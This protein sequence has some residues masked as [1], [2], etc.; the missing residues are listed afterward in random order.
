[1]P[2]KI[3]RFRPT[4]A[5]VTATLALFVALG[6]TSYAALS[7]PANSVGSAQVKNGS[8]LKKDFKAGQLPA[9]KRGPAGARGAAGAAGAA[10][11]TGATG[12]SGAAGTARAYAQI[13]AAGALDT[14]VNSKGITVSHPTSG[15]YCIAFD[16]ALGIG[17]NAFIMANP[18]P[19]VNA[20]YPIELRWASTP[21]CPAGQLG[22]I[23]YIDTA[24]TA[25]DRSFQILVP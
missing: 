25:G 7:L 18:L 23:T 4:Y 8:L 16:A 1:M 17:V 21:T 15:W 14:S 13:T 12:P 20:I 22:V 9:G 11:A 24:Y 2:V 10:G 3:G 5:N 6:G 19:I